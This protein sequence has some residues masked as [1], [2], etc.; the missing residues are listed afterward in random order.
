MFKSYGRKVDSP[1]F[2]TRCAELI[3]KGLFHPWVDSQ[4]NS[5]HVPPLVIS[6]LN[7]SELFPWRISSIVL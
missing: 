2:M 6:I 1:E 4:Y 7:L 5:V 3:V